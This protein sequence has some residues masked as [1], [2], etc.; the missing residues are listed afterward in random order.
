M[1][2]LLE[3]LHKLDTPAHIVD[4]ANIVSQTFVLYGTAEK[5][6]TEI[7]P[8]ITKEQFSAHGALLHALRLHFFVAVA[9]NVCQA[10]KRIFLAPVGDCEEERSRGRRLIGFGFCRR[11]GLG[12]EG[13]GLDFTGLFRTLT[14]R[15]RPQKVN[16]FPEPS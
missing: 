8:L 12:V 3:R 11:E 15:T 6:A 2:L 7:T 13:E 9:A 16:I 4:S 10:E 5:N 14:A 1:D